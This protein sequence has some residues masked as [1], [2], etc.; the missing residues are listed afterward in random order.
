[1]NVIA[2]GLK[3]SHLEYLEPT[4]SA[5]LEKLQL[6]VT[7]PAS[8]STA[9]ERVE[10]ITNGQLFMLI[11]NAGYGYMMPLIHADMSSIKQNF[12]VNV[13]GLLAV[14]Q[15]FFP[16]LRAANGLVVNQASISG[17]GGLCQPFIGTYSASKSAV[18][19]LSNT[20]R[21]ELAPFGVGVRSLLP[22]AQSPQSRLTDNMLRS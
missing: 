8:I 7:S 10:T 22:S 19:D 12:D 3:L 20:L 21:V 14:T 9:V 2:T 1:M 17:L 16:A 5:K 15:A 18:V 4:S 11:N 6:D 13:F